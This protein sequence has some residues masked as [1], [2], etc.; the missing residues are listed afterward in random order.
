MGFIIA[1]ISLYVNVSV[2]GSKF[3]DEV[4]DDI[5]K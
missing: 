5:L 1:A 3:D 4:E 2:K